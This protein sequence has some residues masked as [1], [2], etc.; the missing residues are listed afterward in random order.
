VSPF[1]A[2]R[3]QIKQ[4]AE[5]LEVYVRTTEQRGREKFFAEA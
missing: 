4:R 1:H 2:L 3:E 5:V